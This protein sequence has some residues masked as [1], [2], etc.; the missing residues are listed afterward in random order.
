MGI[1]F[2]GGVDLVVVGLGIDRR[3]CGFGDLVVGVGYFGIG[4]CGLVIWW[5][6]LVI[7]WWWEIIF[8]HR[9][10][11]A[12]LGQRG[13]PRK[14]P[15]HTLGARPL[16]RVLSRASVLQSRRPFPHHL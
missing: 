7:W 16:P 6:E 12:A 15:S 2:W 3:L 14:R 1:W 13:T 8:G 10:R 4:W 11:L 9:A 5:W